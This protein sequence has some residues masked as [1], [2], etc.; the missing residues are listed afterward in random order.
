MQGANHGTERD[1]TPIEK[2][3]SPLESNQ[4]LEGN[5][6][7]TSSQGQ[8]KEKPNASGPTS[9][10]E[11]GSFEGQGSRFAKA[12][13]GDGAKASDDSVVATLSTSDTSKVENLDQEVRGPAVLEGSS[14]NPSE[15]SQVKQDKTQKKSLD[16]GQQ[17][18]PTDQRQQVV[19][20]KVVE[21]KENIVS[22]SR[23]GSGCDSVTTH[24]SDNGTAI[25]TA[26]SLKEPQQKPQEVPDYPGL[27]SHE[28]DNKTTVVSFI[29]AFS[30]DARRT[31]HVLSSTH[32]LIF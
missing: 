9:G 13:L 23:Q 3:A 1:Q 24:S 18:T 2:R 15:V 6:S 12:E 14:P 10:G 17:I 26:S 31:G 27:A 4:R 5:P 20:V 28:E 16:S 11:T 8:E 21:E 19:E 22:E 29:P 7:T 32:G 30:F 25:D